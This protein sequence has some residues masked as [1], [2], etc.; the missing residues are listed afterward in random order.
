[1]SLR[2]R[3]IGRVNIGFGMTLL[4][5]IIFYYIL[6]FQNYHN[7]SYKHKHKLELT[8]IVENNPQEVIFGAKNDSALVIKNLCIH[9]VADNET[10]LTV[11]NAQNSYSTEIFQVKVQFYPS[12][13]PR[14]FTVLARQ[15]IY[16]LESCFVGNLHH[17]FNDMTFTFFALLQHLNGLHDEKNRQVKV[18]EW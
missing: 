7:V 18:F 15:T 4:G 2:I 14:N 8:G 11:Y 3:N 9:R 5:L 1:M 6:K 17:F 12:G 13:I 10:I 16:I